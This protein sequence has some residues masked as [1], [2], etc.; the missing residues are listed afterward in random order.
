MYLINRKQ[1]LYQFLFSW[2]VSKHLRNTP[3]QCT[4]HVTKLYSMLNKRWIKRCSFR[5]IHMNT[6]QYTGYVNLQSRF[7][8]Q[9]LNQEN[10]LYN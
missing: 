9:L 1:N 8:K 3:K 10:S 4:D 5:C 2:T 7:I 6:E